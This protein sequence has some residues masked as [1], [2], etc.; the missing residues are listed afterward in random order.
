MNYFVVLFK[1]KQKKKIINKFKTRKKADNFFKKMI[2]DSDNVFF[3]KR[4]ENGKESYFELAL[5]EKKENNKEQIYIKDELGRSIKVKTDDDNLTITKVFKFNIEESFVDYSNKNKIVFKDFEKKYL[6]KIGLKLLSKLNNKIIFQ[7]DDYIN[8]FT[9]KSDDDC[10]R[11]L[12]NLISKLQKDKRGDCLVVKDVSK[13][14]K[15]YLYNLL[16]GLG[17]PIDYLQRC[18][19]THLSEK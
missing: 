16:V 9:F 8:L 13:P 3:P 12:D 11:F 19:T 7:N 18:S 17:F 5:M 6:K 4:T 2:E 15:K 14:Q 1:N 10:E